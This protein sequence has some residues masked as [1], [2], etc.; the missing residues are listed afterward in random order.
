MM[1]GLKINFSKS[2]I[3]V[4]NDHDNIVLAY[5]EIFNCQIGYFP[6]KYLGVPVSP[7]RL[8]VIDWRPMLDKN[9]KR[10]DVRKGSSMSIAGRSTLISASLNNAPTYHMSI[11][12]L[13]KTV[14]QE[15]DKVRRTFFWQGVHAKR[16]YH[17]VRWPKICK[18]KKKGGLGI[19]DIRI[20]NLSLL[21]KW[22]WKLEMES[23]LWQDIMN[24]KYLR[25]DNIFSV[26]H[27][28]TDSPIWADLLKIKNIY[29]QGRKKCV[30]DGKTTL[31][32]K[33]TWL[34]SDPLSMVS[35]DLFK[36]CEHK[37]IS[38]FQLVNG[39]VPVTFSRWLTNEMRDTWNRIMDDVL[40]TQLV[41]GPDTVCWKLESKGK[42]SVKST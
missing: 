36:L 1:A 20:M 26:K 37:D 35:P 32:W 5:A 13:P 18:S 29:L 28:Q 40:A 4:I 25:R 38:V 16:K 22:W 2:E 15:L 41:S 7:S 34:Y 24:Y 19:K 14:I 30:N 11:Y 17:L 6:I 9:A 27:K 23:G 21:C 42:F 10:L 8:H 3:V 31:V 12:L 33:D 39:L